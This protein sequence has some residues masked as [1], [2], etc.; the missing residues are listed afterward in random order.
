M[1]GLEAVET[2]IRI[3]CR[4]HLPAAPFGEPFEARSQLFGSGVSPLR[5]TAE[6]SINDATE[7]WIDERGDIQ[8]TWGVAGDHA[9]AEGR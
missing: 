8:E 1:L 9:D 7:L 5:T 4:H 6:A 3:P 2:P